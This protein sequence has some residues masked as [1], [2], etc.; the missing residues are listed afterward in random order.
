MPSP[1][2]WL[3]GSQ[4]SI[5]IQMSV[6]RTLTAEKWEF[7][8]SFPCHSVADLKKLNRS[9]NHNFKMLRFCLDITSLD[10][11]PSRDSNVGFSSNSSEEWWS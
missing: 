7:V 8:V 11:P 10:F 1:V 5:L 3:R 9:Q 6:R 2:G 4:K